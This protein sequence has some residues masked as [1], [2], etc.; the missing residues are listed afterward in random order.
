MMLKRFFLIVFTVIKIYCTTGALLLTS[1]KQYAQLQGDITLTCNTS[2]NARFIEF[3]WNDNYVGRCGIFAC[4]TTHAR[5]FIVNKNTEPVGYNI[6]TVTV[7]GFEVSDEGFYTCDNTDLSQVSGI[8]ITYAVNIT[9]VTLTPNTDPISVIE[10]VPRLFRCV[11]STCRPAASVTW[12]LGTTQLIS[13][14]E[15]STSNDV[16][17]STLNYTSQ[18][19]H[20]DMRIHCR[21]SNGGKPVCRLDGS[22]LSSTVAVREGWEFRLN[23]TSD[24]NPSPSVSWTHPGDGQASPLFISGIQRT[25]KGLFRIQARNFLVPSN[26]KAVNLTKDIN[27]TVDVQYP[28]DPPSCRVGSTAILSDIVS[29]IRGNTI[30]INCSCDSNPPSRYSWSVTRV[31]TPTFGQSLDL[32]IR[33]TTTITLT[34]ENSMQFTNGST[35]Q[36]RH[37]PSSPTFYNGGTTGPR[38]TGNSLSVIRGKSVTVACVSIGKPAA[39]YSSWNGASQLW[40]F[41][42][43]SDTSRTCVASNTL[44]PTGYNDESK[45]VSGTLNIKVMYGASITDFAITNLEGNDDLVL[46]EDSNPGSYIEILKDGRSLKHKSNAQNLTLVIGE[47]SPRASTDSPSVYHVTS[48]TDVPASLTFNLVAYPRPDTSDFKW[49]KQDMTGNVWEV[50]HNTQNVEIVVSVDKLQTSLFLTSVQEVDF[51]YY[52][53]NVSNEV[54]RTSEVFHLQLQESS[55][56]AGAVIGGAVGGSVGALASIV[57]IVVFLRRKYRVNCIIV[58]KSDVPSGK[59]VSSA[60]NAE[61]NAAQTYEDISMTTATLGYD[62]M[63]PIDSTIRRC[64]RR[65]MSQ[66][67]SPMLTSKV[68]GKS[69]PFRTTL[70]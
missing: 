15:S 17:T 40:T 31:S 65:R 6:F 16:T 62:N 50:L 34:M 1:D 4:E 18:K 27:V 26:Q 14:I 21:G 25:H 46:V 13:G 19:K 10:N 20:Q 24:G 67:H 53:V 12:Y 3:K 58:R 68:S 69:T 23:C 64:T 37:P 30:T 44:N 49:E 61:P 29:A 35:E 42:A 9:S 57:V 47:S 22:A 70:L 56:S 55:P 7:K 38:I 59:S 43:N 48:V 32:L 33:N 8:Q 66:V 51:G 39:S 5:K 11:T 54:G 63:E 41:T 36:G 2:D 28:P 52:R 45:S 60:E